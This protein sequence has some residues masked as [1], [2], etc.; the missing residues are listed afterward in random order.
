MNINDINSDMNI[1]DKSL[2]T[3]ILQFSEERRCSCGDEF[4]VGPMFYVM[5]SVKNDTLGQIN[6]LG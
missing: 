5:F 1:A 3:V 4:W 6:L 2:D